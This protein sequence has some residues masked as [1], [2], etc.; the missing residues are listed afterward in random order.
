V[1]ARGDPEPIA[2][3]KQ[4]Q[5]SATIYDLLTAYTS[6]RQRQA[7]A[8]VR[9]APRRVWSLAEARAILERMIGASAN[10]SRLD[11]YLIA[12]VV[13]PS[14]RATAFASSLAATLELVREG[15]VEMHQHAA[16]APIFLRRRAVTA[17]GNE[18]DRT[19]VPTNE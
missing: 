12:Y 14:L 15:V 4:P 11:Q 7:L 10:W 6:Q 9:F 8:H 16:F 3:I 2:E 1:F 18:P 13:E 19:P 17:G 5:W